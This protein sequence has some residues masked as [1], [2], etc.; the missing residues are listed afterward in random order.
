M[1]ERESLTSRE[2]EYNLAKLKERFETAVY[3]CFT[4]RITNKCALIGQ[5]E[6]DGVCKDC[7]MRRKE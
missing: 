2:N 3:S 5:A 4:K 7:I 6:F 1:D